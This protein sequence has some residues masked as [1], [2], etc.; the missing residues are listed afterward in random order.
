MLCWSQ[1]YQ[2]GI[3]RSYG[4]QRHF[5]RYL[6]YIVA[7]SFI[8]RENHWPVT[9]HGLT[10]SHNVVS[11]TLAGFKL[12]ILVVIGADCTVSCKSN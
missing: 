5:Q 10:L 6:G 1:H 4:V 2:P 11:I 8:G 7:V 3:Y 12:T 9:Y